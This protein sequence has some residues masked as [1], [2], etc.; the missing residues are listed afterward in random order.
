MAGM[1]VSGDALNIYSI[2]TYDWG[3]LRRLMMSRT[4]MQLSTDVLN[5]CS[6]GTCYDHGQWPNLFS[7]EHREKI[8]D[9]MTWELKWYS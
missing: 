5:V 8:I 9:I 3:L 1:Q 2:R 6:V 4:Q 7:A